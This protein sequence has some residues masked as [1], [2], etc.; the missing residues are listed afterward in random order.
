[1]FYKIQTSTIVASLI[2][3]EASVDSVSTEPLLFKLEKS[4]LRNPDEHDR[5]FS[6]SDNCF[7][8]CRI[9]RIIVVQIGKAC[10]AKSRQ[11]Q[12]SLFW[13]GKWRLWIP[14]QLNHRFSNWKSMFCE[15]QTSTIVVFLIRQVAFAN[16]VLRESSLFLLEKASS[17][18]SRRAPSSLFWIENW[19]LWIRY[20]QNHCFS[21]WKS[22]FCE[23]QTSTVA[24]FL[25][26]KFVFVHS[27]STESLLFEFEK[28][29]LRNLD[30]HKR[31]FSDSKICFC[32]F[33]IWT[34]ISFPHWR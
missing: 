26:D 22:M 28:Y 31:C 19:R 32:E 14:Y 17:A 4:V 23:I 12:S 15:I 9:N 7:C 30:E 10:S 27:V 20:R 29:V 13:L 34:A 8:D 5:C 6:F 1:M 33:V 3:K 18:K 24:A 21:Y 25:I 2:R 16:S 11:A